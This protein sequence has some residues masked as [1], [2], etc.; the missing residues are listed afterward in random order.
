MTLLVDY[1]AVDAS[2][3]DLAGHAVYTKQ[4]WMAFQMGEIV[5]RFYS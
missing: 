1:A 2:A 5:E 3:I 4:A